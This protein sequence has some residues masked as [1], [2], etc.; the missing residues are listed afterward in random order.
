MQKKSA[1]SGRRYQRSQNKLAPP[2][3]LAN[4]VLKGINVIEFFDKQFY[5]IGI[6]IFWG[7]KRIKRKISP[8]I[9]PIRIFFSTLW[10]ML[11]LMLDSAIISPI[12]KGI[13]E[14]RQLKS[15]FGASSKGLSESYQKG[16]F[17]FVK[18]IFSR[19]GAGGTRYKRLA[20]AGLAVIIPTVAGI[21]LL[22]TLNYWSNATYA[23]GVTYK[24][25][26]LGYI[27]DETVFNQALSAAQQKISNESDDKLPA[28]PEYTLSV[29]DRTNLTD[30]D[31][32]SDKLLK[33]S[34]SVI[35]DACGLYINDN[36]YCAVKNESDLRSTL[37]SLLEQHKTDEEGEQIN[38]VD[39]VSLVQGLYSADMVVPANEVYK[40]FSERESGQEYHVMLEGE[41]LE[42]ISEDNGLS[43]SQ[44]I[45]LN[46][47]Y[48]ESEPKPGDRIK[49]T[50]S[51]SILQVKVVKNVTEVETIPFESFEVEVDGQESGYEKVVSEGVEGERTI[52]YSV[53][54]IN[55]VETARTELN[56][57]VT[58]EPMDRVVEVA[59]TTA[60]EYIMEGESKFTWPVIGC[61]KLTSKFGMRNLFN[62][63]A[64]HKGIDIA[65]GNAYGKTI[66]AAEGG[67]V[68][69]ARHGSSG[70][71]NHIVIDHGN[72]ITTLY[73][74]C[75]KLDAKVGQYVT[76]GQPIA[77]VGSTGRSTGPHLHFEVRIDNEP[78]NPLPYL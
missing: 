32:L 2:S 74:H 51:D 21:V 30:S 66:V 69:K 73:A 65:G 43:L 3:K 47:A 39:K 40:Q 46:P 31:T 61:Y 48:E 11:F 63:T 58:K 60:I 10:R 52:S 29:V 13:A 45:Y 76:A 22:S 53:T 28:T 17:P 27:S 57:A 68:I 38:F 71:G 49:I 41:T 19:L 70:Y 20:R 5:Y 36:F 77:K 35:T 37:D 18:Y 75:S 59:S 1:R 6:K 42:S 55:G 24:E 12:K 67:M 44:I 33:T 4:F 23:L 56:A 8:L 62:R 50:D 9:R 26:H 15:G 78:V 25:E 7:F 34:G 72:G 16:F 14:M 64:L 54:Y